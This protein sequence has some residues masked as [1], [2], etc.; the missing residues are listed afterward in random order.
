MG[1]GVLIVAAAGNENIPYRSYPAGYGE[2]LSV[3]SVGSGGP[4]E[5]EI[6][7]HLKSSF[8]NYGKY[9]DLAA[10][11]CSLVSSESGG[12]V[13]GSVQGTSF[14]SPIVAGIAGLLLSINPTAEASHIAST[15]INRANRHLLY[16]HNPKYKS[17][18]TDGK[19][20]F[21]LGKG[22]V[23]ADA[24]VRHVLSQEPSPYVRRVSGCGTLGH[25]SN[26][27][28]FQLALQSTK[29]LNTLLAFLV[30]LLFPAFLCLLTPHRSHT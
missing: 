18:T 14:S 10:P 4:C 11:G 7:D 28:H 6:S 5:G 22:I 25:L 17:Q 19:T 20:F 8:S 24:A 3:S 1:K 16:Q 2:V 13:Q 9:V 26:Q 23:D 12:Q 21:L 27:I 15:L 30:L 29:G